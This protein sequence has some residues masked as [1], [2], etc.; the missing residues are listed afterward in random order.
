MILFF[1]PL[2]RELPCLWVWLG[3]V[4]YISFIFTSQFTV[5]AFH[6]MASKWRVH[7]LWQNSRNCP[8]NYLWLQRHLITNLWMF[9]IHGWREISGLSESLCKIGRGRKEGKQSLGNRMSWF[10]CLNFSFCSETWRIRISLFSFSDFYWTF[11]LL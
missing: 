2:Q 4:W 5:S 8:I 1:L 3:N 6:L 9:P 10:E 11:S 7:A